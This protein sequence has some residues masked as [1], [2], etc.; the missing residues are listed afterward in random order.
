MNKLDILI[1][2]ISNDSLIKRF[3]ELEKIVDNDHLLNKEFNDLLELQK[4]MVNKR[5]KKSKDFSL[6]KKEYEIAKE[7]VLNHFILSEYLDLLEEINYD[8]DL[9]QKIITEEIKIDFE[10]VNS[11]FIFFIAK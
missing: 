11:K 6:A 4:I 7:H 5:E 8:L 2:E 3:K 9:I 10:W 1:D